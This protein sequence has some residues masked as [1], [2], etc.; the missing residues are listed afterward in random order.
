MDSQELVKGINVHKWSVHIQFFSRE[1][2]TGPEVRGFPI[3]GDRA[4]LAH[5]YVLSTFPDL[6]EIFSLNLPISFFSQFYPL[7]GI[8]PF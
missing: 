7:N 2:G 4:L 1:R 3:T 8:G 6:R 5:R